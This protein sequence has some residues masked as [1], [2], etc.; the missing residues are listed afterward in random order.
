MR[1]PVTRSSLTRVAAVVASIGLIA[2]IA[3][4]A[5]WWFARNGSAAE[6]AAA[7]DEALAATR[8]IAVNLQ[9]LDHAGV[10]K[11]LDLWIAS[12]TG[13]LLA[14]FATNHQRYAEQ[15]RQVRTTTTAR[16]VQ[17]ALTD[18]DATAGKA[19]AI[20]A[21]D[22]NTS[23]VVNGAPTPPVAK[24]VRIQ[25]ELVRTPDAGWKAAGASAV[26]S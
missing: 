25:L 11:G 24:Q 10:D 8:Q 13:P 7:R 2:S 9:S 23:Q 4:G 14:E 12:S 20:A 3:F 16:V 22:V 5:R 21:V 6:T 17:A 18:L 26:K 19:N 15:I 1:S